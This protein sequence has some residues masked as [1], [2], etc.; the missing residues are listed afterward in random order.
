MPSTTAAGMPWFV[1][2]K[3]PSDSQ[4]LPMAS[5]TLRRS[6][7]LSFLRSMSGIPAPDSLSTLARS[8]RSPTG[9]MWLD[10][11]FPICATRSVRR[12]LEMAGAMLYYVPWG[13]GR[14]IDLGAAV[15]AVV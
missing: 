9:L 12:G 4:A 10:G 1:T 2:M 8:G 15:L 3:K 5:T 13:C 6:G 14:S 11:T 7:P